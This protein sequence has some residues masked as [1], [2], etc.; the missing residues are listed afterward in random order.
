MSLLTEDERADW[1]AQVPEPNHQTDAGNG[2]QFAQLYGDRVRFDHRRRKWLIWAG[3]WWREDDRGEVRRLAKEAARDRYQRAPEI[4]DLTERA[5]EARFAIVSE[6]RQRLE[7]M[8]VAARSEEP[9]RDPGDRWDADPN[10]L[11]V[12]NGVID[13]RTGDLRRGAQ[14]DRITLYTDIEY[15]VDARCP[16]WERFLDEVLCGD[17]ELVDFVHRAVGYSLTGETTEQCVFTCYGV[18]SNGKSVFLAILR[19]LAGG[20]S[21]NTPFSTFELRDRSSIPNDLASLAGR[22]LVTASETTEGA[23]LNEARLK[24]LTGGDVITARFLHGEFF[25]FQPVLKLWLAVNHKPVVRDDSHGFWRRVRLLPFERRF[26]SDADPVLLQSLIAEL[27]GILVW[28]VRGALLW[29]EDGLR[30]PGAVSAATAAYRAESDP[31]SEF[32]D[33][34]CVVGAGL[35]LPATPGYR[36]YREWSLSTGVTAREVMSLKEFGSRLTARFDR[37]RRNDGVVYRGLGLLVQP[38]GP[39]V[40]EAR[41]NGPV[42][43]PERETRSDEVLTDIRADTRISAEEPFTAVHHSLTLFPPNDEAGA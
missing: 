36:T 28:A 38:G 14:D 33:E 43:D 35:E 25:S 27:A 23:R 24:A 30:V 6:N 22:R 12:A 39:V 10:L 32:V 8:L 2:E 37:K 4:A 40:D 13:L 18:G 7:A 11:G 26:A 16:R 17:R 20:Y 42:K 34:C 21:G 5:K 9:I 31:L 3:D 1:V 19:G 41:V 15:D 29:R